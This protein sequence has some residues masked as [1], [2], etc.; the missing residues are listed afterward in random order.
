LVKI[1]PDKQNGLDNISGADTFQIRS[2]STER[3]I[4]SLGKVDK[5]TFTNILDGVK[6][7]IGV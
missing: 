2:L 3:F 6:I 5:K 1:Q 4:R 7:V